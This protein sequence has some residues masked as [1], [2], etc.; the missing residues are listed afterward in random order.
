M[1]AATTLAKRLVW[2]VAVS[3]YRSISALV[4]SA[5]VLSALV[6]SALVLSALVLSALLVRVRVVSVRVVSVRVV[7]VRV[8]S[9]RV[10]SVRVV[11]VRVVRVRV[12][13]VRGVIIVKLEVVEA[14]V[15]GIL[16]ALGG[17]SLA[18]DI[19]AGGATEPLARIFFAPG[20]D[21][22]VG[23]RVVQPRILRTDPLLGQLRDLQRDDG[24]IGQALVPANAR[25]NDLQLNL[26]LPVRLLRLAPGR[27]LERP[28]LTAEGSLAVGHER[29]VGV[30]PGQPARSPE[31]GER[32]APVPSLVSRDG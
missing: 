2:V 24:R 8:V 4:L 18:V 30:A 5:L 25:F 23:V 16:V 13:S 19:R 1:K 9:V 20:V 3:L 14:E 10:V 11:S 26:R 27:D 17:V 6:L 32:R 12:L 7:S 28:V 22:C 31:L 29:Q 15:V 21:Q